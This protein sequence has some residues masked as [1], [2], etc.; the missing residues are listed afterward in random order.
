MSKRTLAILLIVFGLLAIIGALYWTFLPV[1]K[2]GALLPQKRIQPVNPL[3]P[4][5]LPPVVLPSTPIQGNAKP[6]ISASEEQMQLVLRQQALAFTARQGTYTNTDA[7]AAL[8]D[9]VPDVTGPVRAFYEGEALRLRTE[10]PLVAGPW[11][12]TM[13]ALSARI[14]SETP[15]AQKTKATVTVQAQVLVETDQ[16]SA[17]ISYREMIVTFTLTQ[18][19]WIV[20]RV[21]SK[22]LAL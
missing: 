20:S 22:L 12:Q 18:G 16:K 5:P 21:E 4:V 8:R 7:F 14:T 15:L 1:V 2:T 10:H 3:Q 13:R 11:V 6:S 17:V 9:I 19:R